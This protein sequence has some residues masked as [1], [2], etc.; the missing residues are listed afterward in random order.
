MSGHALYLSPMTLFPIQQ[1][2]SNQST[3]LTIILSLIAGVIAV[4]YARA[5][6]RRKPPGPPGW[7]LIGNAL[8]FG[9]QK[10]LAFAKWGETYGA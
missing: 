4:L 5:P 10:W 2:S 3:A 7:P 6:S 8:D 1:W 9:T